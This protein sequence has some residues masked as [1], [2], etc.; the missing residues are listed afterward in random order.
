[1][2]SS[3][4][5][6]RS[7]IPTQQEFE[8]TLHPFGPQPG[9]SRNLR[10]LPCSDHQSPA[11]S[12]RG[13]P[14][15]NSVVINRKRRSDFEEAKDTDVRSTRFQ[16]SPLQDKSRGRASKRRLEERPKNPR[17]TR[18]TA[19]GDALIEP[20]SL[21]TLLRDSPLHAPANYST[22][23]NQPSSTNSGHLQYV[24][25]PELVLSK[26]GLWREFCDQDNEMILTKRGRH[27][28]PLLQFEAL[29]LNPDEY[30]SIRL[31][32]E[33][34]TSNRLRCKEGKWE[35][36]DLPQHSHDAHSS[37]GVDFQDSSIQPGTHSALIHE[38][39]THPDSF[40]LGSHWMAGTI[41]FSDVRLTN[42]AK[43]QSGVDK[44]ANKP[45]SSVKKGADKHKHDTDA[46]HHVSNIGNSHKGRNIDHTS[47]TDTN[48]FHM[49][50]FHKYRP[51]LCL[52]RQM[53]N[54]TTTIL[55]ETYQ[56]FA[57]ADFVA[58]TQYH[59]AK[60]TELKKRHNPHAWGPRGSTNKAD[61]QDQQEQERRQAEKHLSLDE[62]PDPNRPKKRARTWLESEE[63]ELDG[64]MDDDYTRY[65]AGLVTEQENTTGRMSPGRTSPRL[66]SLSLDRAT[67]TNPHRSPTQLC[68]TVISFSIPRT[69]ALSSMVD[70]PDTEN[71]DTAR[72]DDAVAALLLMNQSLPAIPLGPLAD[73]AIHDHTASQA[74]S[75]N[76]NIAHLTET[77][78]GTTTAV[79]TTNTAPISSTPSLHR[80][81]LLGENAIYNS[82]D[83]SVITVRSHR[84]VP[85][86]A[87]M[88][89]QPRSLE[90]KATDSDLTVT[91][92]NY[93][94]VAGQMRSS[95]LHSDRAEA[96][97]PASSYVRGDFS[98]QAGCTGLTGYSDY[99][100][101]EAAIV[102]YGARSGAYYSA[103]QMMP[104]AAQG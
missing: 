17:T 80:Q 33:K 99:G 57:E 87:Y 8:P 22:A 73:N 63:I 24:P 95:T 11:P 104:D 101:N 14:Q 3:S 59:N 69:P 56:A 96:G 47:S 75:N 83:T 48:L 19:T 10:N 20:T 65:Q 5:T 38:S 35:S 103:S 94:T 102:G 30:Y 60:V 91:F 37:G 55:T 53:N 26:V 62:Q 52:I 42:K 66:Y 4:D 44:K 36:V 29:H 23:A 28:F 16:P 79:L 18:T 64:E 70:G 46:T 90:R 98:S 97:F 88:S 13:T 92:R 7:S 21:S 86:D 50:S 76:F 1:M 81:I 45:Q 43:P 67:T 72:R 100:R 89:G 74:P 41:L 68:D 93:H 51:R 25:S 15:E 2:S 61:G 85:R 77:T 78:T 71:T 12:R 31:D 82:Q 6:H 34:L 49:V 39:Y 54:G 58:V 40:Q 32:F 27:L 84:E 9:P